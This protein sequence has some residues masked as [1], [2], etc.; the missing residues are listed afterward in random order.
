MQTR[1]LKWVPVVND[2]LCTGCNRCIEACDPDSLELRE[3]V[4]VL[5]WPDRCCSQGECAAACLD[6]A[7][8]ME[9]VEWDG[10]RSRGRWAS[11]GRVWQGQ[12]RGGRRPYLDARRTWGRG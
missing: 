3:G 12:V 4:A 11:G 10:D 5:V 6:G 8:R 1:H 2:S 7:M 9:W